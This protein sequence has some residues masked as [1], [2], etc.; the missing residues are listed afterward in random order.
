VQYGLVTF[1]VL[2]K[3]GQVSNELTKKVTA[4]INNIK[5]GFSTSG[6]YR[7]SSVVR[8][9]IAS[10]YTKKEHISRYF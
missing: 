6:E 3:D 2:G 10:F 5:E 1:Q 4:Q 7:G 9:V 8:L